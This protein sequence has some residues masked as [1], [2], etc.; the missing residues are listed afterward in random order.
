[1]ELR[2]YK[3]VIG[4]KDGAE[5]VGFH[6]RNMQVAKL[7]DLAWEALQDFNAPARAEIEAWHR[8]EDPEVEDALIAQKTTT[9]SVN[10]TQVCNLRCTYCAAGGDGSYGD[11]KGKVDLGLVEPQIRERIS[12]LEPGETF[13]LNFF[14]GEPLLHPEAIKSLSSFAL[15]EAAGRGIEV[16]FNITTNGTLITQPI[17][18]LLASIKCNINLSLDGPPELNDKRRPD[19]RGNPATDRA[20][21]GLKNLLSVRDRL[22]NLSVTG[23]FGGGNLEV[24]KAYEFYSQFDFDAI[25]LSYELS[26]KYDSENLK[27]YL[28]EFGKAVRLAAQKGERELRKISNVGTYFQFLDSRARNVNHCGA[29]KNLQYSDIRGQLFGCA[30]LINDKSEMIG[31]DSEIYQENY[32]YYSDPL[33]EKNGCGQCWAR[34]LC[35]GGCM[36]ANKTKNGEKNKK[37]F[38]YCTRMRTQIAL[39]LTQYARLRQEFAPAN[40]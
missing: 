1:M 8:E 28:E 20:I 22:G 12:G 15:L 7:D 36:V 23:V 18:E 29:G 32:A 25:N 5:I 4:I 33:I 9:F 2:R 30:W 17:A 21:A 31:K 37:D 19:V 24:A 34:H 26:E 6:A 16:R 38:E 39:S 35:G 10:I 11:K 3:D 14:G 27:K 13:H 40:D